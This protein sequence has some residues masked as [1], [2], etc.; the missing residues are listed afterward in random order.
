ML[1]PSPSN[2]KS[3]NEKD[4]LQ[5]VFSNDAAARQCVAMTT[6]S[7]AGDAIEDI[8]TVQPASDEIVDGVI[9]NS[10]LGALCHRAIC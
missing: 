4:V 8:D 1:V 3:T 10:V 7:R 2:I 9:H 6:Y 5:T